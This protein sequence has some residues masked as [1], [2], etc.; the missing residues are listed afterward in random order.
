MSVIFRRRLKQLEQRFPFERVNAVQE[1]L[2]QALLAIDKP[3]RDL[4]GDFL[5][6][7]S[8][9]LDYQPA[10]RAAM[11]RYRLV[12]AATAWKI[13]GKPLSRVDQ[14]EYVDM[15]LGASEYLKYLRQ[16]KYL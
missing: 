7:G 8:P 2:T 1:I 11:E 16:S 9:Y 13:A 6:R 10:E 4:L 14:D 5:Q 15:V 3:D 12:A